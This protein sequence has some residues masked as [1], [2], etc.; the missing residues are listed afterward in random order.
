VD[1]LLAKT[2]RF[3]GC[4]LGEFKKTA[5]VSSRRVLNRDLL[6]Y[7]VW[8]FGVRTN[9]QLGEIFG[10]TG[11]AVS[12]RMALLKC[13]AADDESIRERLT[14]IKAIIEI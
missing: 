10:M 6:L 1:Q 12:K 8:Q 5:R 7:A 14:E 2:A 4:D 11:S 13:K 9:S 3:L